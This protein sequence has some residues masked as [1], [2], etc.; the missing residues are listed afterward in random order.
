M[1]L[2]CGARVT[3]PEVILA[4]QS[5]VTLELGSELAATGAPSSDRWR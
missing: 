1:T 2:A 3:G 5:E 4:A